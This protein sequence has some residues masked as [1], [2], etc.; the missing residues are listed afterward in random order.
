MLKG[1][2]T[3]KQVN[4]Y[5]DPADFGLDLPWCPKIY[6]REE[7]GCQEPTIKQLLQMSSGILPSDNLGCGTVNSTWTPDDWFWPYRQAT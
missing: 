1:E 2:P 5:I 4:G 7:E 3:C 6:G